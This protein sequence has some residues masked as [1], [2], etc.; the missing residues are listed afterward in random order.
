MKLTTTEKWVKQL[1]KSIAHC[2]SEELQDKMEAI[3]EP[4]FDVSEYPPETYE[5]SK[6]GE[7]TPKS[8]AHFIRNNFGLRWGEV[9]DHVVKEGY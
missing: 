5:Y 9:A 3:V 8:W 1:E 6:F 4:W 2:K 7:D